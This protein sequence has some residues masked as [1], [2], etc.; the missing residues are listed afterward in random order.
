[1][2]QLYMFSQESDNVEE[3]KQRGTTKNRVLYFDKKKLGKLTAGSGH[4]FKVPLF[5]KGPINLS[6][7]MSHALKCSWKNVLLYVL[8]EGENSR[9]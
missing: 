7:R 9:K 3:E 2:S 8:L 6:L 4:L 5:K 1:M